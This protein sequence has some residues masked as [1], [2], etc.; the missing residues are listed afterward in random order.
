MKKANHSDALITFLE[1]D[2]ELSRCQS[3]LVQPVDNVALLN[4]D[5]VLC[6]LNLKGITFLPDAENRLKFCEENFKKSYGDDL[7]R[8]QSVKGSIKNERSLVTRLHLMKGILYFH[9]NRPEA[10]V[11]LEIAERET[12]ALR[13]NEASVTMLIDMGYTRPETVAGLRSRE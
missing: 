6:Y 8:A 1:A 3:N 11:F 7:K 9:Q 13:V 5:I 10:K 2:E 4:L 12:N